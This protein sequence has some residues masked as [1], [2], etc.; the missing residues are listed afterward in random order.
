GRAGVERAGE[1][2]HQPR[3]Y[4]ERWREDGDIRGIHELFPEL[5]ADPQAA[6]ARI[7]ELVVP[8]LRALA[9]GQAEWSRAVREVSGLFEDDGPALKLWKEVTRDAQEAASD[10][11]KGKAVADL[12]AELRA[13]ALEVAKIDGFDVDLRS[14]AVDRT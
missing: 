1:T 12:G 13:L 2:Y 11:P 4:K 3:F 5:P 9:R 10:D 7:R 14:P 8:R 6:E